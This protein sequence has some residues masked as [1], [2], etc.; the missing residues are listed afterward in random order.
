MPSE[1]PARIVGTSAFSAARLRSAK[2]CGTDGPCHD[3]RLC[4]SVRVFL[5]LGWLTC[6]Q[7]ARHEFH[8]AEVLLRNASFSRGRGTRVETHA[9][10]RMHEGKPSGE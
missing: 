9:T 5:S 2:T 6:R 8:L 3:S 7:C 10:G 4:D 1:G